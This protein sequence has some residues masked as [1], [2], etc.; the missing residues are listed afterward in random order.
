MWAAIAAAVA[1]LRYDRMI[2]LIQAADFDGR[3]AAFSLIVA[4]ALLVWLSLALPRTTAKRSHT[5]FDKFFEQRR[6]RIAG[7]VLLALGAGAL[8]APVIAPYDPTSQLDLVSLQNSPPSFAHLFGT[9][10]YS[11]DIL[12]RV[13]YGARVSLS[14]AVLSILLSVTVGAAVGMVSGFVGGAI[15]GLIMRVI[16]AGLAIPRIFLL[17]VILALWERVG[18]LALVTILGLSSWFGTSRVVR[19]EVLSIRT[20]GYV[21]AAEALGLSRSRT[22]VRHLLPNVMAPIV[23]TATLGIGNMI[24]IEAGLSYLGLGIPQPTPSWGNIIRDGQEFLVSAPWISTIPGIAVVV[25]VML[26]SI[27]G[28]SLQDVLDPRTR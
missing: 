9:D 24:L 10:F 8:V 18:V 5:M 3:L 21:A 11:R 2:E 13:M 1:L 19:A 27:L 7:S 14:I 4:P 15:D 12:S 22:I 20:R 26:F 6:A 17:L 23:V 16:D 28:D 25:T